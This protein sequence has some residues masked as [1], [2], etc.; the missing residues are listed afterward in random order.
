M[1]INKSKVIIRPEKPSEYEEVNKLIFEAFT[2]Q[3]NVEIGRFMMEHFI[4]ERKKDT[5]IPELSIVAVLENGIIV[6]EV[7]LHETDIIT[8]NGRITQLVLSQ[9][10]VLPEYRMQGIMR[11]LVENVLNKAKGMGYGAVFLGGNPNLYGRFGFEPS[12]SYG[13]YHENR[14]KWGDEGFMVCILKA[15][16]L[17]GVTGTTYYYGG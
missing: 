4:E 6:G 12:S 9:S 7:A 2:E 3:H 10:A 8:D 16:V 5:F 1:V 13:I 17:D 14:K 11:T 15:G